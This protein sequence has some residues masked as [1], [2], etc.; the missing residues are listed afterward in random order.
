MS[1]PLS[2][3]SSRW[4]IISLC[5]KSSTGI[6]VLL[7]V[8]IV[9]GLYGSAD[10]FQGD[11]VS[12]IEQTT[13]FIG[14]LHLRRLRLCSAWRRQR[15]VSGSGVRKEIPLWPAG[16]TDGRRRTLRRIPSRLHG[17]TPQ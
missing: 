10:A 14:S 16:G 12:A 8:S 4:L 6:V 9:S 1:S 11:F 17:A 7:P 5:R 3:A 13:S 2:R 15:T